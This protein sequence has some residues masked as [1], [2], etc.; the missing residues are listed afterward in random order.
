MTEQATP[1][2]PAD[3]EVD[4]GADPQPQRHLGYAASRGLSPK[5]LEERR[6]Q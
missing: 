4:V 1:V 2:P 6:R 3:V 5:T